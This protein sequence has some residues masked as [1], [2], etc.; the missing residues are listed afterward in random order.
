M[1]MCDGG[2]HYLHI[3]HS[4]AMYPGR[5]FV[6]DGPEKGLLTFVNDC[7]KSGDPVVEEVSTAV[8]KNNINRRLPKDETPVKTLIDKGGKKLWEGYSTLDNVALEEDVLMARAV[9]VF[10]QLFMHLPP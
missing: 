2:G 3:I 10:P 5:D 7:T 1:A 9:P 8:F 4:T 6:A